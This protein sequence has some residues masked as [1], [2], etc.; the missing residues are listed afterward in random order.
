MSG[1]KQLVRS[2]RTSSVIIYLLNLAVIVHW[3]IGYP[4]YLDVLIGVLTSGA[5]ILMLLV[6]MNGPRSVLNVIDTPRFSFLFTFRGR[7][8]VDLLVSL[9]LYAMD[10][11]GIL[12][13]T[14]TLGMIFGIRFA[15]V[16]HPEA[17]RTLFRQT[18][19]PTFEDD[20]TVYTDAG[21]T[22]DDGG[23]YDGT[24]DETTVEENPATN[25]R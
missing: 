5:T 1:T 10:V 11:P 2:F 9:F 18:A 8:I 22:Y 23:T 6:A 16:K 7:Y 13:A 19:D 25:R 3:T 15:G 4:I 24:Y 21:D 17:F 20:G 14:V 12:M